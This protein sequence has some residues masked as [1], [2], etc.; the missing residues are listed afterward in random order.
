MDAKATIHSAR[1]LYEA[2]GDKSEAEAAQ[3]AAACRREGD[4]AGAKAWTRVRA[5]IS[6][7]RGAH[8]S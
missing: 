6:E 8:Y 7:L 4:D 3:R 1:S 5:A 2:H